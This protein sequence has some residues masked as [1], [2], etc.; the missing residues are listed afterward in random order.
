MYHGSWFIWQ[1]FAMNATSMG[2]YFQAPWVKVVFLVLGLVLCLLPYRFDDRRLICILMIVKNWPWQ[3]LPTICE[4]LLFNFP[5]S[6]LQKEK[7][8][9]IMQ[10][11]LS[12]AYDVL[13][14]IYISPNHKS[15]YIDIDIDRYIHMFIISGK[16]RLF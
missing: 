5:M 12:N 10:S 8:I 6:R 14:Y 16:T 2:D 9:W 15:I 7:I 3:A 4:L 1:N 11:E 13:I